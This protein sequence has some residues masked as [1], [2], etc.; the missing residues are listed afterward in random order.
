MKATRSAKSA[1]AKRS[2]IPVKATH[3]SRDASGRKPAAR[4]TRA[5]GGGGRPA[6]SA[7]S[8]ASRSPVRGRRASPRPLGFVCPPCGRFVATVVEGVVS[9]AERGS[10]PRFCSPACRQAAYRRRRAG[11]AED[12]PLQPTGG[13]DRSLKRD[14]RK[15]N[16]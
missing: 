11:V 14:G 2:Q 15:R 9:R 5:A 16:G 8:D 12:V 6:A 7:S 4:G 3:G 13:R 10:P 1:S